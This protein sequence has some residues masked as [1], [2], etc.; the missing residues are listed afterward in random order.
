MNN[1]NKNTA[2]RSFPEALRGQESGSFAEHTISIRLPKIAQQVLQNNQWSEITQGNL[3]DLIDEMPHGRLSLLDDH[4][5][6]D[7]SEW[8]RY[9]SPYLG[10]TWLQAPWFVVEMYFFR[11]ILKAVNFFQT[12][13]GVDPYLIQKQAELPVTLAAIQPLL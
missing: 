6:P 2:R 3:Q 9:M 10:M 4:N 5:A 12:K 11:R 1:D 13:T 8:I 7:N